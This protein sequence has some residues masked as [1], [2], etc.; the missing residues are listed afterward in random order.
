MEPRDLIEDATA[1][2]LKDTAG[3]DEE[4]AAAAVRELIAAIGEDPD[5]P[6]LADTPQRIARMYQELFAG[7]HFDPRQIL[8]ESLEEAHNEMVIVRDIPFYSLCE[9]HLLPFYGVAHV[10]YV[11]S[12]R[13]VGISKLARVVEAFAKR[14]QVQE[15]LTTQVAECIQECLQ[16][17]GVAVVIEAEHLCM[18]M[19][20]VK[21]PGSRVITSA[22]RGAF[23]R[24]A[25]SRAEFLSLVQGR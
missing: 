23:R 4:R 24:R 20:G 13:V 8:R 10:G 16:P 5:R 25:V 12:G 19:R 18:T 3:V 22:V 11:P 15:R 9:H 21:K 2:L 1:G 6:G 7:V 17:N 14:P